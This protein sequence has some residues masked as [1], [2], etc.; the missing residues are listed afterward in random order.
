MTDLACSRRDAGAAR[1]A[2]LARQFTMLVSA[3]GL[4]GERPADAAGE[5][6]G[7]LLET[8]SCNGV[9]A[10]ETFAGGLAQD[11]AAF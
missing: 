4:D 1:D 2:D 10:L 7:W 11:R 6:A 3:C 8:R 9:A 5:L